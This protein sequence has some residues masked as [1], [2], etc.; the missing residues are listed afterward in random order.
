M[1]IYL[2][3]VPSGMV[4]AAAYLIPCV[5]PEFVARSARPA[6]DAGLAAAGAFAVRVACLP[7]T[8]EAVGLAHLL[9][10]IESRLGQ[11]LGVTLAGE[12]EVAFCP[13]TEAF[14][15]GAQ[16]SLAHEVGLPQVCLTS[17]A[18]AVV[19]GLRAA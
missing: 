10:G 18:F 1:A 8:G 11:P 4:G 5:S 12:G 2:S 15:L 17:T 7:G 9:A 3:M 14:L 19:S 6:Q 13:G 16:D